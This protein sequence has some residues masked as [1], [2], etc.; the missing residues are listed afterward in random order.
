MARRTGEDTIADAAVH[1]DGRRRREPRRCDA[2]QQ[3]VWRLERRGE[4]G[5]AQVP[6]STRYLTDIVPA[7]ALCDSG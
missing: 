2:P 3:P 7:S 4:R 5:P 1:F 6:R